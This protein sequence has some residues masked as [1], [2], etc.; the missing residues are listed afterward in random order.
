MATD[1]TATDRYQIWPR[2]EAVETNSSNA[3]LKNGAW[4]FPMP[5]LGRYEPTAL[6]TLLLTALMPLFSAFVRGPVPPAPNAATTAATT[7]AATT[8]YSNDAAPSLS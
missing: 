2:T 6:L 5:H 3:C 7:Q 8:T 4:D 1:S